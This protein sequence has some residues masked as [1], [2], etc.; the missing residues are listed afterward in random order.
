MAI[1]TVS[2]RFDA[3]PQGDVQTYFDIDAPS[4]DRAIE[5][6]A[7]NLMRDFPNDFSKPYTTKCQQQ[8]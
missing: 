3:S 7:E 6:A 8:G 4:N 1:F 2:F 5:I